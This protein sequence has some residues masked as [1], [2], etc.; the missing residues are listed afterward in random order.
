[1]RRGVM[2]LFVY[3]GTLLAA[4]VQGRARRKVLEE[5]FPGTM[6]PPES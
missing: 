1:M 5:H 6:L 3:L 2:I 4:L